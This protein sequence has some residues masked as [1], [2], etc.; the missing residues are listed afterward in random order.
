MKKI[1]CPAA[2]AL[3][4]ATLPTAFAQT[5]A[6]LGDLVG[7]RGSSGETQ[8]QAR[9]YQFIRATRVRDQSWTFWWSD[10]QRQ[11][12]AVSTT[13]GRYASINLVPPQ[14]CNVAGAPAPERVAPEQGQSSITLI[15]YG[16]ASR[17][18]VAPHNGYQWN[19]TSRHFEPTYGV[20]STTEHFRSEIQVDIRGTSGRVRPAD[21]MVPP[22]H[23]GGNGGWWD[24]TD[25]RV[26]DDKIS[27]RYHFSGLNSPTVNIDRRS[28]SIEITGLSAFSGKCDVGDWGAG[29]KF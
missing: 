9:G 7:A 2:I 6:D 23:S 16:E 14:N 26:G 3:A 11:C 22:I 20:E 28:G 25:L 5:P 19:N 8:L 4:F 29:R 18:S 17:P 13:D 27:G 12:A 24:L 21:K 1:I 10:L 15:C